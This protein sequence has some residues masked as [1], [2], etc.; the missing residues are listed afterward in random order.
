MSGQIKHE[1]RSILTK[2]DRTRKKILMTAIRLFGESGFRGT[3]IANIAKEAGVAKSAVFWYFG[4]KEGLL[5]N[6][7]RE[8]VAGGVKEML[9]VVRSAENVDEA[10]LLDTLLN[11]FQKLLEKKPKLTNAYF[12]LMV[13]TAN[14]A[15]GSHE[16]FEQTMNGYQNFLKMLITNGQN[17]GIFN[18]DWTPDELSMLIYMLTLS[19]QLLRFR[20]APAK[21]EQIYNIIKKVIREI[22][23]ADPDAKS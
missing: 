19:S 22:V 11:H 1:H 10:V 23:I 2:T 9:R 5:E 15:D 13:E 4:S 20:N 12:H 18:T 3:S 6:V 21:P 14:S 8:I 7:T 16:P 17:K